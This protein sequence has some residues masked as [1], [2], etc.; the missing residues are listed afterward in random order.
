MP[1]CLIMSKLRFIL[2]LSV[3]THF[4]VR[5]STRC[6]SPKLLAASGK[7]KRGNGDHLHTCQASSVAVVVIA[8]TDLN[9]PAPPVHTVPL[10]SRHIAGTLSEEEPEPQ[11]PGQSSPAVSVRWDSWTSSAGLEAKTEE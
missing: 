6:S 8:T 1:A 9:H 5:I 7:R 2:F 4:Q 10:S 11:P 3:F